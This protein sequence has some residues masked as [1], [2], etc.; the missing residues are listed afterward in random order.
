MAE[1]VNIQ[2]LNPQTFEFQEYSGQDVSLIPG[3]SV[4][5]NWDSTVDHIE[6]FIYD[7]NG[8]ILFE[9]VAGYPQ[10][11]LLNNN[12]F[13][14]PENDLKSQGFLEGT[15]NTAYNFLTY[16][17]G[18]T[19]DSRYYISQIST[20][21]TEIRLDTTII[22]NANVIA[23]TNDFID[24]R[25][26]SSVFVDFYVDFGNNNL[27]IANNILLDVADLNN[28]TVLIKLYEPLPQQF[29]VNT[30]CWVVESIADP[31]AYNISI[32]Q[33][34]DVLD[35]NIPLQGPNLNIALKDQ[36]N[37][38]TPFVN[39]T[40]LTANTSAQGTGSL[41]YQI[42]SLLAERGIEINIDYSDYSQFVSFG[43]A[44]TQLENFY[45]KLTLLE[46][47]QYSASIAG[48][49]TTSVY[50]SASNNVW[51]NKI[52]E[53]IT[54]FSGYEYYL[55]FE[56]G[57][58]AWPKTNSTYPYVNAG[59]N[60]VAGLAFLNAQSIVAEDYDNENNNRL[61]NAIPSYLTDDPANSQY[62]LF[63]DMVGQNFDSIWV[64]IKDVTNKFDADN[65]L[66][67]GV[68]KDLVADILRDLGVKI[69][70]NNFSTDDLYSALLGITPSGSLYNLPYTTGS[71]PVP[72]GTFLEYINTYV[73]ASATGSLMPT[74]DINAE[75]YKRIYNNLPYLLKKKGT[76]EGLRALI[77][78]YG[79]P[80][81]ILRINEFGGKDKNPNTYDYW[82]DEFNYAFNISKNGSVRIPFTASSAPYGTTY[83]NSIEFR[84]QTTG[85]PTASISYSQSLWKHTT[86]NLG[87]VLEYTGSAYTS[88]S[89]NGSIIDPYY[90]YANLKF[91]SGSASS[92]VYLP[93]Y[94]GGWWSVMVNKDSSNVYT[95]YAK[96]KNYDGEDGNIIGF[97]ASSSLS[98]ANSWAVSGSLVFGSGSVLAGKTY[99]A[100][101]GSFQEIR[102]Y[103][104]PLSES[105]FN[106]YVM[107][108]NSIEGNTISGAQSSKN[109]LF[110]RLSLGGELYTS[111]LSI[112]PGI[113]GSTPVTQSFIN[114]NSSA[115]FSGS[116][117]FI[118]NYEVSYYDQVP[119]GIRNAVSQ[120]IQNKNI[121]LPFTSS[122]TSYTNIPDN[123]VLSPF[124]SVQQT[125]P[126]SSSYTANVDYLEVAFSPQNEINEDINDQIG[127]FNIGEL[128][129]DPREVPSRNTHYPALDALRDYYFEKYTSNYN[130]W[131]YVRLIKFFDNSL[132]KMIQDWVPAHTSLS[133]GVV[134]KQHL[135][136]RNRY[137]QP[138]M[139]I[140]TT[141]SVYGSGSNPSIYWSSPN[142]VE[143]IT[144]TASIRGIPGILDGQRI[145]TSSTQYESFPIESAVG[146]QGGVM[147]EFPGTASTNLFVNITQSYDI[148]TPSLLG[149]VTTLHDDKSEF[150]NGELSGSSIIVDD[151]NL[152]D[153]DCLPYLRASTVNTPYDIIFYKSTD[154]GGSDNAQSL[155][156]DQ[157]TSPNSGE[158]YIYWDSGSTFSTLFNENPYQFDPI[159]RPF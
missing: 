35:N 116:Y 75:T 141:Q 68:S 21:R 80:D 134:I 18:S 151:G 107:N 143:D 1:I 90:Q 128:I 158:I 76:P 103:N 119:S 135:L 140:N 97:Q 34:F 7:L 146:G 26:S 6:Y 63:V 130:I 42:N 121:V 29:D 142:A 126:A 153:P 16:R 100:F 52:N 12:L 93:F 59:A 125:V 105:A 23:S 111:S 48:S 115:T 45:Y 73:T 49:S 83:P 154:L 55:Y 108:P 101:S 99:T 109:S 152:T 159:S 96:D 147:P 118:P 104:V 155:F 95:L 24:Y 13:I 110:F 5:D 3:T 66:N 57:S 60:S 11:S 77:T 40:S 138:Q 32:V 27:V 15:Y 64:Y 53:I 62:F 122:N 92:S 33:T 30:Q 17:L 84:F 67:Y 14:D 94:N 72:A 81:T 85:L 78:L 54:G 70:Q 131:D 150:F 31:R 41:Q 2:Q 157:N 89:Y 82:Q 47:Y 106:A 132:F 50:I 39:Y 113:T 124:I 58:T 86:A 127:Y 69:Y 87:V 46:Q 156:L 71:L 79:I 10:Y 145:F 65:R 117:S 139:D 37:N 137:P 148:T 56:S 112:H 129:G 51:F 74:Y 102:Y 88:G 44:Q 22:S 9:N 4:F 98:G 123:Q 25:A 91:I 114:N 133:S 38:S 20:D 136:E 120:K 144:I 36:I 28:P 43:S 61:L 149:F 19:S 8:N